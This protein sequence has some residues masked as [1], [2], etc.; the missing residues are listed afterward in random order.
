MRLVRI[1]AAATAPEESELRLL[2]RVPIFAPLPGTTIEHLVAR[3]L[4]LRFDA[5][6]EIIRQGDPG[7]RFYLVAEGEV[8]VSANGQAIS[9]LGPGEYF[10]EI[11]L[12]R[13][14]PRTATVKARTPV[15]LYSLEREDFLAAVTGHAPS[16]KAAEAIMG[17]RLAGLPAD[18]APVAG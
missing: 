18:R 4:P 12:L 7:D 8:V 6:T 11:A 17:A 14:V 1:D 10:G 2:R 16:A 9:V 5:G 15:V 3:L 13:D